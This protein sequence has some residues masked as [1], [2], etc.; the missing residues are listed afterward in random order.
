MGKIVTF[1]GIDGCGKSY[2]ANHIAK[3]FNTESVYINKKSM[4]YAQND[5]VKKVG[6]NIGHVLWGASEEAP[7]ELLE[8][9][10]WLF[11]YL[12]WLTIF[13]KNVIYPLKEKYKYIFLDGWYYKMLSRFM[14]KN[15]WGEDYLTELFSGLINPDVC[16]FLDIGIEECYQRKDFFTKC[17]LGRMDGFEGNDKNCFFE[18]QNMIREK[19]I[20]LIK[21]KNIHHT[22]IINST[23]N[24]YMQNR[25]IEVLNNISC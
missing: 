22:Y 7:I 12:S 20:Y 17:E 11:I 10:G 15:I 19:Y 16:F 24:G 13:Q 8:D 9:K 2:W 25:I 5:Y 1:E 18:Y 6:E 21:K 3:C 14:A 4:H 23:K